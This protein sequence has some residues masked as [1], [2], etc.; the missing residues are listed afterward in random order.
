MFRRSISPRSFCIALSATLFIGLTGEVCRVAFGSD[1]AEFRKAKPGLQNRLRNR[2]SA[3]RI[4][5]LQE[6][7]QFEELA[8]AKMILQSASKDPDS[9]VRAAARLALLEYKDHREICDQFA[10]QLIKDTSKRSASEGTLAVAEVLLCSD[11]ERRH[12]PALGYLEQV[13]FPS[14]EGALM[15]FALAEELHA[16][17]GAAALMRLSKSAVFAKSFPLRRVTVQLLAE[18]HKPEAVDSLIELLA[19]VRGEV[20]ADVIKYLVGITGQ[21]HGADV[22]EWK[23]WWKA[24]KASFEYPTDIAKVPLDQ[25]VDSQARYYGLPLYGERLVFIMDTSGS[26]G[27]GKLDAAKRELIETLFGLPDETY[28][29]LV[30][31]SSGVNVWQRELAPATLANKRRAQAYV[32]AQRPGGGTATY[33]ALHSGLQ[34]DAEAIYF[35]SDG[36]PTMGRFVKPTEILEAVGQENR[37]RRMSIYAIGIGT[38]GRGTDFDTFMETLAKENAGAFRAVE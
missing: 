33:S 1:S 29:S 24:N 23:S 4:E 7:S 25:A 17:Q 28:F 14:R 35:L 18:S 16:R 12:G 37:Y 36:A 8:T 27:G 2:D 32:M 21:R 38:G 20:R 3:M 26:M 31:F 9:D 15:L 5:A 34:F 6:L 11:D 22:D 10:I 13:I 30:T 19:H